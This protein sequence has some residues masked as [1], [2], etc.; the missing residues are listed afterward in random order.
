MHLSQ[1]PNRGNK[2]QISQITQI[3]DIKE[4]LAMTTARIH[5]EQSGS[6]IVAGVG[7]IEALVA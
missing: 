1:K 3:T 7:E 2:P 6:K 4:S 5:S